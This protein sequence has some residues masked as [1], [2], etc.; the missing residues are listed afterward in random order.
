MKLDRANVAEILRLTPL[1][2]GILYH[3]LASP[4]AADYL[5]QLSLELSGPL[6]LDR[7]RQAWQRVADANQMLRALFRW[8]NLSHPVQVVLRRHRPD[9]RVRRLAGPDPAA[10]VTEAQDADRAELLDLH[11]PPWRVTLLDLGPNRALMLLTSHH[12]LWDGWS[13]GIILGEFFSAYR[14]HSGAIPAKPGFQA[15]LD[16]LDQRD[17]A[18]DVAYWRAYLAGY[19]ALAWPV[20]AG[21]DPAP[22]G[23]LDLTLPADLARDLEA[24]ARRL[25]LTPA[26]LVHAAWALVMQ[27]Y[28][29]CRDMAVGSVVAGR[30]AA[31]PGIEDMAGLC[32]NTLPLRVRTTPD[33]TGADLARAVAADLIA[34][35]AHQHTPLVEVR[36]AANL[37][38]GE[39]LFGSLVAVEN[40]PLD[41]DRLRGPELAVTGHDF[42]EQTHYPIS[43]SYLA[44]AQPRCV[45]IHREGVLTPEAGRRLGGHLLAMLA[46]LV[47]QPAQR[48]DEIEML[49]PAERG[50]ILDACNP[51]PR[52]WSGPELIHAQFEA[53]ARRWPERTALVWDDGRLTYAE[54][55][56]R[57]NHLAR[58]LRGLGLNRDRLAALWLP[59]SPRMVV[60]M[61]AVFKAGGAYLPLD[62]EAPAQR[63]S[64]ILADARPLCLITAG[65]L[66]ANAAELAP[67]LP[68]LDLD[69][70]PAHGPD[71][72]DPPAVNLP[73]DL[74]YVIY[75]SGSTGRP[76]GVMVEHRA[77][78]NFLRGLER[79]WPVGPQDAY[80]F[81]TN[82]T[83]DVSLTELFGWFFG[84]SRLV[85]LGPGLEREPAAMAAAI[86]RHAVTH[87][88]FAPSMLRAFLEYLESAGAGDLAGVKYVI[89]AGEALSRELAQRF[90]ALG[91]PARL[92]DLYGPTEATV[93]CIGI[94]V[95]D[96]HAG[97]AW[98]SIGAPLDNY[99]AYVLGRHGGLQPLSAPGELCIGGDSLARGY[100]GREK[101]TAERFGADPFLPGQRIYR[102]GDLAAWRPDGN[103][104][105][106]GRRDHQVKL[107]GHRIELGEVEAAL[108]GHPALRE[109]VA[110]V[111]GD[112]HDGEGSLCAYYSLRP[113]AEPHETEPEALRAFLAESLPHYMLPAH[114]VALER[115]PWTSSGKVD[116]RALP[117]PAP[118]PAP[119]PA[120]ATTGPEPPSAQDA[121]RRIAAIWAEVLGRDD[122]PHDVSFFDLGGHSIALIRVNTRLNRE[123]GLELAVTDL[124][125]HPTVND[126][127][128]L[129]GRM[130]AG[131]VQAVATPA[132]AAPDPSAHSADAA[133]AWAPI[134]V[135]GL[136]G[137]FP[138]AVDVD[139][140]WRNLLAGVGSIRFFSPDELRAAGVNEAL[141]ND[142]AYVPA[143]GWLADSDRFDA[144]FF[145]Y[146]EAEAAAMDPQL[147]LLHQ[148]ALHA[149]ERTGY[150][151]WRF[152]GAIGLY[153]GASPNPTWLAAVPGGAPPSALYAAMTVGERD[154]L[155]SRVAHRLGLRGPAVTVQTACSTSLV[156][157]HQACRALMSG[158]CDLT[159]AGGVGLGSPAEA[160]YLHQPGMIRSNDGLCRPFD[161]AAGGIV[162]GDGVALVALKRL[163]RALADGDHVHAVIQGGWV[164]NDGAAKVGYTAPSV[165]G[166]AEVI[167]RALSL[168][169]A[170]AES[171]GL[172][173]AHGTGTP[174][175]D[176]VE[177]AALK[178]AFATDRRGYCALGSLKA[179][180]GHLD[181]A[182]GVAGLIKAVLAVEHGFIPPAVNFNQP[183]PK[184]ELKDSPFRVVIAAEAWPTHLSPRRAGVSSFGIGGT[185]VHLVV[186]QA[187]AA[188]AAA[189][190]AAGPRLLR[191]SARTPTAL[192]ALAGSL[193]GHLAAHPSTSLDDLAFSLHQ[194]RR[195]W[196]QRRTLVVHDIDEARQ[197]L[198]AGAANAVA[199]TPAWSDPALVLV[200]PGQGAQH[201]D[202]GRGLYEAWP[203]FRRELDRCLEL[204]AGLGG[205]DLRPL[206]YPDSPAARTAAAERIDQTA[207]AQPLLFASEYALARAVMGLGVSPRAMIGHSLGEYV[208]ACLAGVFSLEDALKVVLWRGRAMQAMPPGAMCALALARTEAAAL[209]ERFGS[210]HLGLAAVNSPSACVVS[211]PV[212]EMEAFGRFAAA[213]GV[214]SR[215]LHTSHAFHS[216]LMEPVMAPL[217]ELLAG[218]DLH[219]PKMPFASN[220][221]GR[222]ITVAQAIDPAYW[223][224]HLRQTVLFGDGMAAI[225]ADGPAVCIELGPGGG[226]AGRIREQAQAPPEVVGLMRHPRQAIPDLD[227]LLA[228]L[229]RLWQL[230]LDPAGDLPGLNPAGRRIPLP[231]Y[232]FAGKRYPALPAPG[233]SAAAP[234]AAGPVSKKPL[235]EDWLYA[236]LW[237][238]TP[239]PPL[240]SPT[241]EAAPG[242]GDCLVLTDAGGWGE[243]LASELERWGRPVIRVARGDH[244]RALGQG[245]YQAPAEAAGLAGLW[246]LLE[247]DGRRVSRLVCLWPL[248][249]A[250]PSADLAGPGFA[251]VLAVLQ[252][253][254]GPERLPGLALTLVG[255]GLARV[256][257][258]ADPAPEL[259]MLRGLCLAAGQERP[260]LACRMV[261]LDPA[262]LTGPRGGSRVRDLA[263][264]VLAPATEPLAAWREGHRWVEDFAPLSPAPAQPDPAGPLAVQPGGAYLIIGGLGVIGLALAG[265]LAGTPGVRL[266]LVGRTALPPRE[267]W[268]AWQSQHPADDPISARLA[269]VQ[270][271]EALGATV[272]TYAAD[273]GDAADLLAAAQRADREMGPLQGVIH[274][275]GDGFADFFRPLA[276]MDAA[277]MDRAILPRLRQALALRALVADHAPA[278]CVTTSS[279]STVLGGLGLAG[280][281]SANHY[282]DAMVAA[283]GRE[284][285]TAWLNIAWDGWR[286]ADPAAAA[287]SPLAHLLITPAEG[288][289]AFARIMALGRPGRVVVSSGDLARR[290]AQWVTRPAAAPHAGN[291]P[292]GAGQPAPP[293]GEGETT[294]E[295]VARIWREVL[296]LAAPTPAED[297]FALGGDSLKAITILS[298]IKAALGKELPLTDFMAAPRLDECVAGL[299]RTAAGGLP[300]ITPALAQDTYPLSSGQARLYVLQQMDPVDTSHVEAYTLRL[301]G[302]LDLE[303]LHAAARRLV[304][305]HES[306][307][308]GI[309][310]TEDG[311]RQRVV[312]HAELDWAYLAAGEAALPDPPPDMPLDLAQPPLLRLRLV[313]L[314]PLRH[315][316]RVEI[317]HL[318]SDGASHAIFLRDLLALYAGRELPALSLQYKDFA[319]WQ[320]RARREGWLHGQEEYW[321]RHFAELPRPLELPIDFPRPAVHGFAG[322]SL[323]LDLDPGT[324]A[325]LRAAQAAAGATTFTTIL[326]LFSILLAEASGQ[327]DL[328]IGAPVGGRTQPG[329]ENLIGMFVN[330]AA[331][332]CRVAPEMT[333]RALLAELNQETVAAFANQDYPFEDL[334]ARL[335]LQGS[336]DRNPLFNVVF[337][338]QKPEP[339]ATGVEGLT[340]ALEAAVQV[341]THFDL[342]LMAVEGP[343]EIKATL[344]YSPLLF[345]AETIRALVARFLAIA[346]QVAANPGLRLHELLPRQARRVAVA[347][348]P[349]EDDG[350]FGF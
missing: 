208:A 57:A 346:S 300:A 67:G 148:C 321:L 327:T 222:L 16:F 223:A 84:A 130:R 15:Y 12:I 168:A 152:S 225:L 192:A 158:E 156:A 92:L 10:W 160:G 45:I 147:R 146:G 141:L 191:L 17:A 37:R 339:A 75:T 11:Q 226:L 189:A 135:I 87:L 343:E 161:A 41:Q 184:L 176:P 277:F 293:A 272:R 347:P 227:H 342:T 48:V 86:A 333:F 3:H 311:P 337:A 216:A 65:S 237:R 317:H 322:Q 116:R 183:N 167:R 295:V 286:P 27:R 82:Y 73:C 195:A 273:A 330:M 166:Q 255:S 120:P 123:F 282:L 144:E 232:P 31:I 203:A 90:S 310:E 6:E 288:R 329:L 316:L 193:A 114:Y 129:V 128:R 1:Q 328:V 280:Y 125:A 254:P 109:A 25:R 52:V 38:A 209:L 334:V 21:G 107:Q 221:H 5:E 224:Q 185:N 260:G 159:L 284:G 28:H 66:A 26:S 77:V 301:E 336:L 49:A 115:L 98:V 187:P 315:M 136:A 96:D 299:E 153:A 117:A 263:A 234:P 63:L 238:E 177:V 197:R 285:P 76:K 108:C 170:P 132:P 190:P 100:L 4:G 242:Q 14:D 320:D 220:L 24:G 102:T 348:P 145:G 138:G 198:T 305:R 127:A 142:P 245:R 235:V 204:L 155:C 350:D 266:A 244:A 71:P 265:H 59:R 331:L 338:F 13:N 219:P 140:L 297:F 201:L 251:D 83:F 105:F 19:E 258:E 175:G 172:L 178:A 302:A 270:A 56:R 291:P 312:G 34:H 101:L 22:A 341:R 188:P 318:I 246:A 206:L 118:H 262:A 2:E 218:L 95:A 62:P 249:Q 236:P 313:G 106:M 55:N 85:L 182:A 9:I 112:G 46:G 259:P 80:L 35:Q 79:R 207:L 174:L 340:C 276:R 124:F 323:R 33:T 32:I 271:L 264:E 314:G 121:A 134:A 200:F 268:P 248:D 94:D 113:G 91:L 199:A 81:K 274:A 42:R 239:P 215:R 281:A 241:A 70:E 44:H 179:N 36:A 298:R 279:L 303:R 110:V 256:A 20:L 50:Q 292:A 240:P 325:A 205:E 233:G 186:Q 143:K 247:Q 230:G 133:R 61:L 111:R 58:R 29:D 103:L 309:V 93:F 181:A 23:R 151:P 210:P 214:A 104:T 157:V 229:G 250:G 180:L 149:L 54:V 171:I 294:A 319:L 304:A 150:D 47:R 126:L 324:T 139:Q 40:Y 18:A 231:G 306:L 287:A 278:W 164:N 252:S 68:V 194:G 30:D 253:L 74:A 283:A 78:V 345:R 169:G 89:A 60:A 39:E 88:N 165:A 228:G 349:V 275:A 308:T 212:P 196:E 289:R 202:M 122:A 269:G 154:F 217:A 332:R 8:E 335:N 243:A 257:S 51:A 137:R 267:A 7:F 173:E 163:D 72:G 296:G 131:S 307:R 64:E 97:A 53:Q 213:Q 290:R 119:H 211:G 99:R 261:D 162:G 69:Q 43:L 326:A 344:V